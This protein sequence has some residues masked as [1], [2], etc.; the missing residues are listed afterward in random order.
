MDKSCHCKYKLTTE[1]ERKETV[2]ITNN[3][4]NLHD[5]T[6]RVVFLSFA[7]E[8]FVGFG[9]SLGLPISRGFSVFCFCGIDNIRS[10]LAADLKL[11]RPPL[12]TLGEIPCKLP[13]TQ[14]FVIR[15]HRHLSSCPDTYMP[16]LK[17]LAFLT[18][19]LA[20]FTNSG[21]ENL[22]KQK[23]VPTW[24]R[25]NFPECSLVR[26]ILHWNDFVQVYIPYSVPY[27]P[28]CN[29]ELNHM[30]IFK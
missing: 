16:T 9:S 15:P 8:S 12:C 30:R 4:S 13:K 22:E 5:S 18:L 7:R 27:A 3:R 14:A 24:I 28:S 29:D 23:K 21:L 11:A 25:R 19:Y 17:D 2:S 20:N 1:E 10:D 26:G 6:N